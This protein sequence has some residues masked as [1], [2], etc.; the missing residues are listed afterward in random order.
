MAGS[1]IHHLFILSIVPVDCAVLLYALYIHEE[2]WFHSKG[3][4][5]RHLEEFVLRS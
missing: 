5:Q 2:T 1:S 4:I 3:V